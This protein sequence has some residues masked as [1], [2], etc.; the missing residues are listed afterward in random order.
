MITIKTKKDIEILKEGGKIL[1]KVLKEVS[2]MVKPG[3]CAK[4]LDDFAYKFIIDHDSKPAF[5]N[6]SA[7]FMDKPFPATLCVSKNDI[8]V[9]GVPTKDLIFYEGDIVSIDCGLV[10]KNL[11]VDSAVTVAVGKI[12]PEHQKL[13]K[14][15]KEALE[16]GIKMAKKNNTLGDIG[17]AIQSHIE[18]N[19]FSVIKEL[20]GHGVGYQLHEEPEIYNFGIPNTGIKLQ[21]GY[22]LALEPMATKTETTITQTDNDEFKTANDEYA[23][24]FEHTIVVTEREPIKVTMF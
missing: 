22:V 9:H 14:V 18:K 10:Y 2:K 3:V 16:K 6:Y 20:I 1:A 13:M 4:D 17:H 7:D 21:P 15:T 23:A 12:K 24:H 11:Y 8:I 5:L 19:G